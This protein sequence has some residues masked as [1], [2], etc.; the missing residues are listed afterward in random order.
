MACK[1]SSNL[2]ACDFICILF[3]FSLQLTNPQAPYH[4]LSPINLTQTLCP[5]Y[6]T[7]KSVQCKNHEKWLFKKGKENHHGKISRLSRSHH[8]SV[9][10]IM[11]Q[12][13]PT[14]LGD[15]KMGLFFFF[16]WSQR[17]SLR[18]KIIRII[19]AEQVSFIHPDGNHSKFPITFHSSCSEVSRK[20]SYLYR[21]SYS[22]GFPGG[23]VGE[24]FAC[25][26]RRHGFDPWSR[27]VPQAS[28]QLSL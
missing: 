6:H 7:I 23:S 9:I 15:E 12:S 24:S 16:C 28:E 11:H 25:Q 8:H 26:G 2:R 22:Q 1:I 10:L 5:Q 4:I 3:D 17:T 20:L 13:T 27:T 21:S 19:I 18:G 14:Q